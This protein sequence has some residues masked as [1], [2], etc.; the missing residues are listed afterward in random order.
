MPTK[1]WS[2]RADSL[3]ELPDDLAHMVRELMT[4]VVSK[5]KR[6]PF[7]YQSGAIVPVRDR[8]YKA[9]QIKPLTNAEDEFNLVFLRFFGDGPVPDHTEADGL[10]SGTVTWYWRSN[11]FADDQI[12]DVTLEVEIDTEDQDDD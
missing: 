8:F 9:Q 4:G 10:V 12:T 2:I 11:V 1:P 6:P 7:Q 3:A 5:A